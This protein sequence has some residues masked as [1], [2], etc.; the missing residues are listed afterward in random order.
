MCRSVGGRTEARAGE[1]YRVFI[2]VC[3]RLPPPQTDL[4]HRDLKP[5]NLML[6]GDGDLRILDFGLARFDMKSRP[7][8][9]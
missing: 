5:E 6:D 3:D 1:T 7:H 8:V 9:E 4:T 2:E